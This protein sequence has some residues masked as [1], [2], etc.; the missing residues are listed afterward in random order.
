MT[1]AM[2]EKYS[3][4][5]IDFKCGK[6]QVEIVRALDHQRTHKKAIYGSGYLISEKAA[7]EKAAAEKAAALCWE[8]S[9][10]EHNIIA[11]LK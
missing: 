2:C 3:K 9:E 10:R 1:A 6:D 11:N 8:L 7:A 5:G 4:Y